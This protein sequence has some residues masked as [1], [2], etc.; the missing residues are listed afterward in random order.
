MEN[1]NP[2]LTITLTGRPPVKIKKNE[3]PV[4]AEASENDRHGTQVGNEPDR[5]DDWRLRVRKHTDGR[6][7]V[8]AVYDYRSQWQDE[9]SVG[10]R[11][12]ELVPADGDV[13]EALNR[14]AANMVERVSAEHLPGDVFRRLAQ[15]CIA[16]LPAVEI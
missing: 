1:T 13:V 16:D 2:Y 14:V 11:G 12:G 7:I 8:Y 10:V 4:L 3:W 5:E 6:A 15:E 9:R